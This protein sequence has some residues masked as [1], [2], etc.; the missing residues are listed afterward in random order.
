MTIC[1]YSG[2]LPPTPFL[3]SCICLSIYYLRLIKPLAQEIN[4]PVS[5]AWL[6]ARHRRSLLSKKKKKKSNG[7]KYTLN[8]DGIIQYQP[9]NNPEPGATPVPAVPSSKRSRNIRDGG[10]LRGYKQCQGK[11]VK[12]AVLQKKKGD[13]KRKG[14]TSYLTRP[15]YLSLDSECVA[16]VARGRAESVG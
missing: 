3:C 9:E 7:R 14:I 11:E 12:F 1:D 6:V 13:K 10:I 8:V 16:R 4:D 5:P 15:I 2:D